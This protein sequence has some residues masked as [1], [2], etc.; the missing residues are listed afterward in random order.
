[1]RHLYRLAYPAQ[2]LAL[3]VTTIVFVLAVPPSPA[4]GQTTVTVPD[5]TFEGDLF[6]PAIGPRNFL[7][8]DAPEVPAH[9]QLSLGLHFVYQRNAYEVFSQEGMPPNLLQTVHLIGTQYRSEL[10]AA[11][12]LLDR[13]QLGVAL[14]FTYSLSGDDVDARTGLAT[15][16]RYSVSGLGDLR[17]EA[18]G[19]LKTVG[20]DDQFVL[21]ALL[22]GTAPTG[23]SDSY[24]GNKGATGRGKLLAALQLGRLRLGG[25]VGLLLRQTTTTLDAKVGSQLLYGGGASSAS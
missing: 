5:R 1:M 7:T 16:N 20:D 10:H 17:I 6:Q 8:I 22:G 9:K 13:F 11:I 18:K 21:A 24:L 3:A 25:Q 2:F 4:H 15:G 23:K 14:P 19:Q 12:G